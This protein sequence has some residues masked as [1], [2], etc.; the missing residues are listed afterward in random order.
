MFTL[1]K[2][3][4]EREFNLLKLYT[5]IKLGEGGTYISNEKIFINLHFYQYIKFCIINYQKHMIVETLKVAKI[6]INFLR[7][8]CHVT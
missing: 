5:V 1:L 3:K 2:V 7:F 6:F 4:G 8:S